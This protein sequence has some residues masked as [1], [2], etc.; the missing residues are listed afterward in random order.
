MLD[1]FAAGGLAVLRGYVLAHS[2]SYVQ[3]PGQFLLAPKSYSHPA[4]DADRRNPLQFLKPRQ[5]C[6][7]EM[8]GNMML[9]FGPVETTPGKSTVLHLSVGKGNSQL[10]QP[11]TA[12]VCYP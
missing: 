12:T 7:T 8:P 3:Q 1:V 4:T 10:F 5:Q 6:R 9:A 2:D 11:C